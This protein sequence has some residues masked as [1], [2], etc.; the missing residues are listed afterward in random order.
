[1]ANLSITGQT[2][3]SAQITDGSIVNADVNASAAIAYS[4][5]NLGTSI[6]NA[7]VNAS[8]AIAYSKLTLTNSVVSADVASAAAI[9]ASKLSLT[10]RSA[11]GVPAGAP[12]TTELPLAYDSTAVTGGFYFWTG[13]AWTKVA[14]IV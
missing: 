6:V 13:A 10:V 3:G 1:M 4:K 11:A 8:A 12:T 14:T 7:D 2:F 5:L 9:P